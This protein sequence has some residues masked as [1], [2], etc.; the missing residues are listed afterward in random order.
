M[1][2]SAALIEYPR[3]GEP[4]PPPPPRTSGDSPK[5]KEIVEHAPDTS[6]AFIFESVADGRISL[7]G[8]PVEVLPD[9]RRAGIPFEVYPERMN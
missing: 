3:P 1:H 8:V 4:Q 2:K 9:M 6:Y 5:L 7:T